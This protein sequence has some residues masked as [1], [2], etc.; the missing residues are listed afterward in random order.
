MTEGVQNIKK[1]Y[2]FYPQR[3]VVVGQKEKNCEQ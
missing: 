2:I 1:L 3:K